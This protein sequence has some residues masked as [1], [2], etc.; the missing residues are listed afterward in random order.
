MAADVAGKEDRRGRGDRDTP[1]VPLAV[2]VIVSSVLRS[3][4]GPFLS[5]KAP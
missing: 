3:A 2:T 1:V 5:V 4:N